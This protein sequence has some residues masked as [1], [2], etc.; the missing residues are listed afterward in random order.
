MQYNNAFT[1]EV[2]WN[3]KSVGMFVF[4]LALP[5]LLGMLNISTVWGF[6][7]HLFQFGIFLAAGIYGWKGGLL[8]GI[9]GS[10]FSAVIMHNP[11]IIVF[12][13]ILG[14][15]VGYFI[16]R[17]NMNTI[18]AVL[19]A[20]VIELPVLILIDYYLVGLSVMFITNL[21]IALL[22]SNMIWA[23]LAHYTAKPI[24]VVIK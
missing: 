3:Y 8:S 13:A 23:I 5:N 4:L 24:K 7:L 15:F 1:T 16:T 10:M 9:V 6:K 2:K 12:N 22:I 11:Y 14:F 19:L 21:V 18:F 17:Y 20:F